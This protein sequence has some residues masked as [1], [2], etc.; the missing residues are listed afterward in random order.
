[1]INIS[2]EDG[3]LFVL[4]ATRSALTY[5]GFAF[6]IFSPLLFWTMFQ[7]TK[8]Y[9]IVA[10]SDEFG[11]VLNEFHS[12]FKTD[13]SILHIYMIMS[14]VAQPFFC[15]LY[16][17]L[18]VRRFSC[19]EAINIFRCYCFRV[20]T[21]VLLLVWFV[22]EE[23]LFN[24]E[25]KLQWMVMKSMYMWIFAGLLYIFVIISP[26]LMFVLYPILRRCLNELNMNSHVIVS[27]QVGTIFVATADG[28]SDI[29]SI[30]TED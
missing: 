12:C 8:L 30:R 20:G 25:G 3:T 23:G 7:P 22:Y 11:Y 9:D 18:T 19:F 15:L 26:S 13:H 28:E 24:E 1:M 6:L 5:I 16:S 29:S 4:L 10:D 27:G 17:W 21:F 14:I 2:A